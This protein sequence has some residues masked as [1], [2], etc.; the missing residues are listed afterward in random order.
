[1]DNHSSQGSAAR[2]RSQ[3]SHR[4]RAEAEGLAGPLPSLLLQ[5]RQLAASMM[6]GHH[7]RRRAGTGEAFW[8]YRPYV[9]GDAPSRID[10]RLSGRS[11]RLFV[12]ETE[13]EIA[14]TIWL[15]C[16]HS[17]SMNWS[18]APDRPHKFQRAAVL[19]VALSIL[20]ARS[21]ERVGLIGTAGPL[22]PLSGQQAP[23]LLA[24]ALSAHATDASANAAPTTGAPT[25]GL[26]PAPALPSGARLIL[27]SDFLDDPDRMAAQLRHLGTRRV[28]ASLLQVL[29]PAE[30]DL[31]YQGRVLYQG[32]EQ[33][34]SL[35][36]NR[37]ESLRKAYH[38]RLAALDTHLR[39]VCRPLGWH[40]S[41]HQSDHPA[42]D[43]LLTLFN[44]LDG[45][46][47]TGQGAP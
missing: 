2:Q 46:G 19:L 25:M 26:P 17:A 37:S 11:D 33:E 1:M 34:D 35:L 41:R 45:T 16:D 15:W 31:P 20:L 13:Q 22:T 36:V 14:E 44:C 12:R 9:A 28:Q 40:F 47:V 29:D 4:L 7:G 32:L 21:G 6:F 8:Q 30:V 10:W 39:E 3:A 18:S 38:D 27:I 42:R 24:Q 23:N 5:A 43:A